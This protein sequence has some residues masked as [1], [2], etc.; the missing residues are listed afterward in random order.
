MGTMDNDKT[1]TAYEL[2]EENVPTSHITKHLSVSER[3]GI[4]FPQRI[5]VLTFESSVNLSSGIAFTNN[6]LVSFLPL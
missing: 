6:V 4:F 2:L 1:S 3:S 5:H